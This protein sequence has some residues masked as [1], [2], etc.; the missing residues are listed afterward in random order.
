MALNEWMGGDAAMERREMHGTNVGNGSLCGPPWL[1]DL[2]NKQQDTIG[3]MAGT[4][5]AECEK[6]RVLVRKIEH[7]ESVQQNMMGQLELLTEILKHIFDSEV[8]STSVV[9]KG[10][11]LA[12]NEELEHS[13][14]EELLHREASSSMTSFPSD[15]CPPEEPD[16]EELLH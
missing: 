12:G 15:E 11:A 3:Q 13:D 6:N 2:L 16:N 1:Y 8:T 14:N 10:C 7:F 5:D 4:I 9:N